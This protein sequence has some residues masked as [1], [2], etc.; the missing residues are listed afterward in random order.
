M[1]EDRN[2]ALKAIGLIVAALVL[3]L[4]FPTWAAYAATYRLSHDVPKTDIPK[5][6]EWVFKDSINNT[7]DHR[8]LDNDKR[9]MPSAVAFACYQPARIELV[10]P[11]EEY[12][13]EWV[14]SYVET[15]IARNHIA[16]FDPAGSFGG[17]EYTAMF[18]RIRDPND[19]TQ[20]FSGECDVY[21][22]YDLPIQEEHPN[23]FRTYPGCTSPWSEDCA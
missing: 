8:L 22:Y 13:G 20:A 5:T 7:T 10:V 2:W 15:E 1:F 3:A 19:P 12:P 16:Y 11:V 17:F 9:I 14:V 18:F 4:C 21:W 23:S 6:K